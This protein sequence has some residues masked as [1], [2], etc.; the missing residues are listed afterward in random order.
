MEVSVSPI[1]YTLKLVCPC[2]VRSGENAETIKT[3]AIRLAK[4][5]FLWWLIINITSDDILMLLQ[6]LPVAYMLYVG[7][8]GYCT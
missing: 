7:A 4:M 6:A 8:S 5:N 3:R 2:A 1:E